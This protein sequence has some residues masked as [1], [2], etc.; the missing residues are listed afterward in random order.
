MCG[1]MGGAWLGGVSA[2]YILLTGQAALFLAIN[3]MGTVVTVLLKGLLCG[4]VSGWLYNAIC[5]KNEI[6][7]VAVA[8]IA[9]PVVNTGIFFAGCLIFF[10]PASRTIQW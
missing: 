10:L 9:C 1:P 5:R 7:S 4:A 8:A 6:L 3:P 2:V